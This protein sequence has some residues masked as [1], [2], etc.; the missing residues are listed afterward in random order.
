MPIIRPRRSKGK[1]STAQRRVSICVA[2]N[3]ASDPIVAKSAAADTLSRSWETS[4][5]ANPAAIGCESGPVGA[6]EGAVLDGFAQ[7]LGLDAGRAFQVCDG[8]GDF[9][10]AVVGTRRQPQALNG[11]L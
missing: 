5:I 6:V 7:V 8:A 4:V 9:Q 10:D 11:S 2:I 3:I 1:A